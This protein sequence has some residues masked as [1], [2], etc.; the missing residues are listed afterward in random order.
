VKVTGCPA[1]CVTAFDVSVIDVVDVTDAPASRIVCG[2]TPVPLKTT[3]PLAVPAA[4]GRKEMFCVQF[5]PA[6]RR[7]GGAGQVPPGPDVKGPLKVTVEI[8][9]DAGDR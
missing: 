4:F 8:E 5:V 1:N 9:I 6:A 7:I 2:T 3:D